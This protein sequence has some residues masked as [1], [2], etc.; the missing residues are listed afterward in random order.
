MAAIGEGP[1]M[2]RY[3]A[4]MAAEA[5]AKAKKAAPAK[6]APAKAPTTIRGKVAER[7]RKIN[8]Y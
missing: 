7:T 4:M 6:A 3:K 2:K 1:A 5:A 8:G